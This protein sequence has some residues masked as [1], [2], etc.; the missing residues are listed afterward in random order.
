MADLTITI[1][2][3]TLAGVR[4]AFADVQKAFAQLERAAQ[5]TS[6]RSALSL[7]RIETKLGDISRT[8]R[9]VG[10]VLTGAMGAL[11]AALV[12]AG[13]QAM[14]TE[15]ALRTLTGS[16]QV[17]RKLFEDI[18]RE[19][20]QS[21]MQR[22][23]MLRSAQQLL[24]AQI[25]PEAILPILR[26]IDAAL[27]ATGDASEHTAER[28]ARAFA[29]I[30]AKGRLSME[31]I[32][33]LTDAGVPALRIIQ[34]ELGLTST[35]MSELMEGKR[36]VGGAQALAALVNGLTRNFGELRKEL[37]NTP[38]GQLSNLQDNLNRI[39]TSAGTPLSRALVDILKGVN[40]QLTRM[41]QSG[42]LEPLARSLAKSLQ[43]LAAVGMS[44]LKVAQSLLSALAA[45]P[46]PLRNIAVGAIALAGPAALATSALANLLKGAVALINALRAIPAAAAGAARWLSRLGNA[47]ALLRAGGVASLALT[48]ATASAQTAEYTDA[49]AAVEREMVRRQ[50]DLRSNLTALRQ[51]AQD[52]LRRH[53]EIIA[54]A[55]GNTPQDRMR[56]ARQAFFATLT[57]N[58]PATPQTLTPASLG[59][60]GA[61]STTPPRARQDPLA[62]RRAA[63][64]LARQAAELRIPSISAAIAQGDLAAA[65]QQLAQVRSQLQ[66]LLPAYTRLRESEARAALGRP[67]SSRERATI[68]EQ[69]RREI[70]QNILNLEQQIA[71]AKK[72]QQEQAEQQIRIQREQL[73]QAQ[74]ELHALQ[75]R[76]M[77]ERIS[78]LSPQEAMRQLPALQAMLSAPHAADLAQ[79]ILQGDRARAAVSVAQ[80]QLIQEQIARRRQQLEQQI[81]D[82]QRKRAEE[83]YQ[84][85]LQTAQVE[86]ELN[87]LRSESALVLAEAE[88]QNARDTLQMLQQQ[89][90]SR[91]ILA[92]QEQAIAQ[93]QTKYLQ[94]QK[95]SLLAAL[96][97]LKTETERLKIAQM[98]AAL[99]GNLALAQQL[100]LQRAQ[101]ELEIAR[102]QAGLMQIERQLRNLAVVAD[103]HNPFEVWRRAVYD[104]SQ[105]LTDNLADALLGLRKTKDVFADFFRDLGRSLLRILLRELLN[106]LLQVFQSW[107]AQLGRAIFGGVANQLAGGA[108]ASAI[109]GAGGAGALGNFFASPFGKILGAAGLGYLGGQ[110]LGLNPTGSAIGAGIG[111]AIGGPIGAFVGGLLGGLIGGRRRQPQPQIVPIAAQGQSITINNAIRLYL[112]NREI[113]R[114]LVS[115]AL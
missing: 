106:P 53:P 100:A 3:Q 23:T 107:A 113:S 40:E 98:R 114:A 29:Q 5:Q 8:A 91:E 112:D 44:L 14:A 108:A 28:I 47:A 94:Q 103:E 67:P 25:K 1:D 50:P 86:R 62:Q 42:E 22:A 24:A 89:G 38:V 55:Q 32:N 37:M 97:L 105:R 64:D 68:A 6:Q 65:A 54:A 85:A 35:Q 83:Q 41:A 78:A 77:E 4:Q 10:L 7:A 82:E 33:Q 11:T 99:E 49:L 21:V 92:A 110:M 26:G 95:Q 76:L 87:K 16:A 101:T 96:E 36:T 88:L 18:N 80:I 48:P 111:M 72:R 58:A 69:T 90:A 9:N 19:A 45:L 15:A 59:V 93:A 74:R 104:L 102:T 81:A 39:L 46:E 61:A 109:G 115:N 52:Y 31:E 27:A 34:Q 84:L 66:Q 57:P 63:L 70:L 13:N 60:G 51:R 2:A 12:R 43:D 30:A 71:D 17:G 73:A 56:A 75:T 79:G 20:A